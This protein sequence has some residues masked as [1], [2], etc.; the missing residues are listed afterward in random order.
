MP[1]S[2]V[3]QRRRKQ[4]ENNRNDKSGDRE[5]HADV[6]S[7]NELAHAVLSE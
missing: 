4:H 3:L 5:R 6:P 1:V 7:G 2:H